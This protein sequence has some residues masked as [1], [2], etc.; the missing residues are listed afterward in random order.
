[1]SVRIMLIDATGPDSLGEVDS[2]TEAVEDVHQHWM[3]EAGPQAFVLQGGDGFVLAMMMR[4]QAD[5]E[6][7]FTTFADG[8][9]EVHQCR[10]V[11][12]GKGRHLQTEVTLLTR[13]A[14]A[15]VVVQ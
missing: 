3:E 11:R 8:R 1:M 10:Y 2:L 5:S 9:V 15:D 13:A 6:V 4:S 14:D 12:D 7:C